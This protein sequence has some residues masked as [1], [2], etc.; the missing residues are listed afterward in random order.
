MRSRLGERFHLWRPKKRL[1]A[2]PDIQVGGTGRSVFQTD[3]AQ[4][5]SH[6]PVQ[7]PHAP[8][9]HPNPKLLPIHGLD[10]YFDPKT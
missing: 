3:G 4:P 5:Q 6:A 7:F 8:P 2:P 9:N 10:A 1:A